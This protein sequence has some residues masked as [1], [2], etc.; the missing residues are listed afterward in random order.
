MC[1][2]LGCSQ[3]EVCCFLFHCSH[4]I[5]SRTINQVLLI[6]YVHLFEKSPDGS[7]LFFTQLLLHCYILHCYILHFYR[8]NCY[9]AV[10]VSYILYFYSTP[11]KRTFCRTG[12][13]TDSIFG[14][15][16]WLR[17][18]LMVIGYFQFHWAERIFSRTSQPNVRLSEKYPDGSRLL[19]IPQFWKD[20]LQNRSAQ[21]LKMLYLHL[22]EEFSDGSRLF[23]IPQ[24]PENFIQNC[25]T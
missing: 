18:L 25:S 5:I 1:V 17:S 16:V 6:W 2:G 9:S 15:C 7:S 11:P 4:S 10:I 24:F 22:S 12:Q 23:R 13:H 19:H 3:V 21:R 8:L 14:M 20:L